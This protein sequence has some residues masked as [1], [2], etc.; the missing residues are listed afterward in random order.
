[1]KKLT[2]EQIEY[3]LRCTQGTLAMEGLQNPPEVEEVYRKL[4]KG[5]MSKEQSTEEILKYHKIE[6]K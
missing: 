4:L 6:M 5:E 1:M 2:E 3:A